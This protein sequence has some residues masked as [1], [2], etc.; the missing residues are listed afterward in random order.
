MLC[1]QENLLLAF[2]IFTMHVCVALNN[3][4]L[5]EIVSLEILVS[6]SAYQFRNSC[7]TLV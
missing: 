5:M 3:I 6:F 2:L 1:S 4:G 7:K